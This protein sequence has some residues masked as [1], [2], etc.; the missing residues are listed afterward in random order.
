MRGSSH[1]GGCDAESLLHAEGVLPVKGVSGRGR[2]RRFLK[3][4]AKSSSQAVLRMEAKLE[5]S[6]PGELADEGGRFY[7]TPVSRGNSISFQ[8]AVWCARCLLSA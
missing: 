7:E 1:D 5:I 3:P 6:Q 4:R 8:C 2:A